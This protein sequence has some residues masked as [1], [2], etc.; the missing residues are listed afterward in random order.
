MQIPMVLDRVPDIAH[1]N[2]SR[3]GDTQTGWLLSLESQLRLRSLYEYTDN[4]RMRLSEIRTLLSPGGSR[5]DIP[6]N[7]KR[8]SEKLGVFC[9]EAD[10]WG[11]DALF[12]VAQGLQLL[13]LKSSGRT[14]TDAFWEALH[15][16]L[17]VISALLTQCERDFCW[18]L[19]TADTLDCLS[20][21]G[22]D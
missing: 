9:L 7:L 18:R 1:E 16:G 13:L 14:R 10:S 11:F 21:A 17:T 12:S 15:R 22:E 4:S 5:A 20:H 2:G 3:F 8:A 19:A 6:L